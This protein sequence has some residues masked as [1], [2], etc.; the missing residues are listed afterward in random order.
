MN[1]LK[2]PIKELG[3]LIRISNILRLKICEVIKLRSYINEYRQWLKDN[4]Y[5]IN[6]GKEKAFE[7]RIMCPECLDKNKECSERTR[8]ENSKEQRRRYIKRKR[9]LCIAFGVCRECLKKPAKVGVKCLEC[10]VKEVQRRDKNRKYVRRDIRVELGLCYFCGDVAIDG[11]RTCEKHLQ[12][13]G[14]KLRKWHIESRNNRNH[15]WR[16]IQAGEIENLR[17]YYKVNGL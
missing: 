9:D 13:Q 5:C 2:F 10:H 16:K 4:G 3:D 1:M 7:D 8:S 17:H 14:D 6:C 12:L 11:K 15:I